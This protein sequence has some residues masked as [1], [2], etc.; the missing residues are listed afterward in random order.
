MVIIDMIMTIFMNMIIL[1]M[2]NIIMINIMINIMIT[3]LIINHLS[4]RCLKLPSVG[5]NC[6]PF[7][8]AFS[9]PGSDSTLFQKY[10]YFLYDDM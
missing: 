8:G 3:I 4:E 2:I 6:R 5:G 10:Y 9:F 7:K 1:V